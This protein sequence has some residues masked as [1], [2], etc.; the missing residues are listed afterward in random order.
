MFFGNVGGL[1]AVISHKAVISTCGKF[2]TLYR[3]VAALV[4][5]E[6]GT[7]CKAALQGQAVRC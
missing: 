7:T 6:L 4:K 1:H 2:H 3:K 5:T